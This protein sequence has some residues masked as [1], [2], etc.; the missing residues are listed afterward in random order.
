MRKEVV[1][2]ANTLGLDYKRLVVIKY[3]YLRLLQRIVSGSLPV[4]IHTNV[5]GRLASTCFNL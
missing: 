4:V 2:F 3:K 1:Q 5:A